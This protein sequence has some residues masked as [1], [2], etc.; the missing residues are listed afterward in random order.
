MTTPAPT[1][2]DRILS[3][4]HDIRRPIVE[5]H[6]S[7]RARAGDP[8]FK[9]VVEFAISSI[10]LPQWYVRGGWRMALQIHLMEA[11]AV[12]LK[13]ARRVGGPYA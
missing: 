6:F 7:D 11:S 3:H 9:R 2:A 1:C 13:L 10:E 8:Q 12:L 4:L 5:R